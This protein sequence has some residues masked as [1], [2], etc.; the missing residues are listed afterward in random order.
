MMQRT[1][2]IMGLLGMS[3]LPVV[4]VAQQ[5]SPA[6]ALDQ[7]QACPLPPWPVTYNLTQSSMMYQPWC[8]GG[9]AAEIGCSEYLNTSWWWSANPGRMDPG[10]TGPVHWGI[11]GIDRSQSKHMWA[12]TNCTYLHVRGDLNPPVASPVWCFGCTDSCTVDCPL[13]S[14]RPS[15]LSLTLQTAGPHRATPTRTGVSLRY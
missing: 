12:G 13:L 6:C 7:S 9:G 15:A 2:K 8:G 11:L 5:H 10:S 4:T 3:M 1:N 14:P